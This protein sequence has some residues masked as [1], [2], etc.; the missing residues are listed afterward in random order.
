MD[1]DGLDNANGVVIELLMSG[2][3]GVETILMTP[4]RKKGLVYRRD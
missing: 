2:H 3:V 4:L 1:L